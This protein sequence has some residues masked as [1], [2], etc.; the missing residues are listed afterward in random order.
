M[1]P[2]N[3]GAQSADSKKPVRLPQLFRSYLTPP[4]VGVIG[5]LNL[6]ILAI[7]ANFY[8]RCTTVAPDCT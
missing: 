8:E 1:N 7:L 2:L 6:T 5:F 4:P 3:G